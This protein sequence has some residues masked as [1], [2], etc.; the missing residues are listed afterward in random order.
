MAGASAGT[1][2]FAPPPSGEGVKLFSYPG[3][4]LLPGSLVLSVS[5]GLLSLA[6]PFTGDQALFV[7]GA[8]QLARGDVLYREFWDLKQPG[9]YYFYLVGGELFG[10]DEVGIHSLELLWHTASAVLL[11]I[12]VRPYVWD[13]R[14]LALIPLSALGWYYL[15][16][17]NTT[18]T[19]VESLIGLPLLATFLA[20]WSAAQGN[21]RASQLLVLSGLAGGLVLT[22]KL[23]F[24][25]LL[26]T[27]WLTAAYEARR[28]A[29]ATGGAAVARQLLLPAAGAACVLGLLLLVLA[30]QGTL[31]HA[32]YTWLRLPVAIAGLPDVRDVQALV[33]GAGRMAVAA[34]PLLLLAAVAPFHRGRARA[35]VAALLVWAGVGGVPAPSVVPRLSAAGTAAFWSRGWPAP[36]RTT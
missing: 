12:L 11:V 20:A 26:L 19:Q 15:T 13:G 21:R 4:L 24:A 28:R 3:S 18:L 27:I 36:S 1:G 29:T 25:P 10:Y 17:H 2:A 22:F 16:A 32:L 6:R 33:R 30:A 31:T 23:M 9:I 8:E 5:L 14:T 34:A 35:L 7:V